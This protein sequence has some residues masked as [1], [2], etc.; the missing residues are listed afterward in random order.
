MLAQP[1]LHAAL[2]LALTTLAP[3]CGGFAEDDSDD[4]R[5]ADRGDDED[6]NGDDSSEGGSSDGGSSEGDGEGRVCRNSDGPE[7][8]V[9]PVDPVD[10]E[11]P[12]ECD[13]KP[14]ICDPVET[15]LIAGQQF[16]TGAVT[17]SNSDDT[18]TVLVDATAPY[19]LAEVHVYVGTDP[20]PTTNGGAAAPGQ[21]PYTHEFV[22]PADAWQL[23]LALADLDVGCGDELHVAVHATVVSFENGMEVFEETAWAFGPNEFET[24]WGWSLDYGICCE[25]PEEEPEDDGCT[26]TRGY[27]QTHNAYAEVPAL[28]QPWP[29]S[30]DTE[31]CGQTWLDILHTQPE[32]DAWVIL[33][34]QAIATQLNLANDASAPD[35]VTDALA[36]TKQYLAQCEIGDAVRDDALSVSAQLDAYNNGIIGPGHCE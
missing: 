10:P 2:L 20:V 19:E 36:A 4:D 33:A 26:L 25:E 6:T 30:E 11:E 23:E 12:G 7:E 14:G 3:A 29:L 21:F 15:G 1:R 9:D 32:G 24:S 27:W 34:S 18:I 16:D 8:P 35:T 28:Q 5:R 13:P 22:E 17:I 31:L